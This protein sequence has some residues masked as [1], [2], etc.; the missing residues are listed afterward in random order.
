[1]KAKNILQKK[2]DTEITELKVK[3]NHTLMIGYEEE[4]DSRY[5][6]EGMDLQGVKYSK[7]KWCIVIHMQYISYDISY[8]LQ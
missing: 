7:C 3:C 2:D 4:T 8:R 6:K 1:M 5:S